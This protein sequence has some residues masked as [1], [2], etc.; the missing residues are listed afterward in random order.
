MRD[1]TAIVANNLQRICKEHDL[2]TRDLAERAGMP[3]K[4]VHTMVTGSNSPRCSNVEK[5]AK[6]LLVSPTALVTPNL[7]VAVL[8]SRRIPRFVEKYAALSMD[9]RDKVEA[10][11]DGLLE[12]PTK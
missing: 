1:L 12:N 4:T 3:Q 6:A 8:M 7:P 11:L 2:S 5:I 9:D 10:I